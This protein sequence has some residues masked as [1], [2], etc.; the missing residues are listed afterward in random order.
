[1]HVSRRQKQILSLIAYGQS[2]KQIA[3]LLGMSARTVDSH[4]RRLYERHDV[5]SRAALVARWL[6]EGGKPFPAW[7][8]GSPPWGGQ[9]G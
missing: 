4:L 9:P 2:D 3:E 7:P 5:H 8:E 1:M 6:L